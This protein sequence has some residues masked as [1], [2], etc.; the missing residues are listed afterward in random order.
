MINHLEQGLMINGA[1]YDA[2]LRHLR[3]VIARKRK[4]N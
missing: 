2:E 1:Y 4:G 3:Q